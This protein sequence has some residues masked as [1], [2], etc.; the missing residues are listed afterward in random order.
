MAALVSKKHLPAIVDNLALR[1]KQPPVHDLHLR[2]LS[3]VSKRMGTEAK[4]WL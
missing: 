3:S 2:T 1:L 4:H